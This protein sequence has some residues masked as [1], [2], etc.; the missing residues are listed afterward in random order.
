MVSRM[1]IRFMFGMIARLRH[2]QS[3]N[4]TELV[5]RI[6]A[7]RLLSRWSLGLTSARPLATHKDF[8]KR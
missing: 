2:A 5:I 8:H 3:R 4:K 1:L 7:L 6:G